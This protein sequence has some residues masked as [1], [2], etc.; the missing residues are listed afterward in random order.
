MDNTHFVKLV[1]HY[2]LISFQIRNGNDVV[3]F[4][5][6]YT[7]GFT[8]GVQYH[9][10]LTR[11]WNN[12][13]NTWAITVNGQI[14]GNTYSNSAAWPDFVASVLIGKTGD[15][16]KIADPST[17]P[18][19]T[20]NRPAFSPDGLLMAVGMATS[21]YIH[22]YNTSDWSKLPNPAVLPANAGRGVAFSPDGSLMAIAHSFSPYIT[23]YNTSDWS[24]LSN[25][26]TLPVGTG[27]DVDFNHDGSLMAVAH[28]TSPYVTI[29]NTSD[30]SKVTNPSTLPTGDA[31]G[32]N[33]NRDGSLLT[34]E[35]ANSPYVTIYNTSDWS[36]VT[37]PY[38]LPTGNGR[39]AAFNHDGSLM[40][41]AH[42][43][44]PFVTVYVPTQYSKG[45][46]DE[47]RISKGTGRWTANFTPSEQPYP[48]KDPGGGFSSNL[49]ADKFID[50]HRVD[51][52]QVW[53]KYTD[54]I[55]I[56]NKLTAGYFR[57]WSG[58]VDEIEADQALIVV[59]D[60]D[61]IAIFGIL[62][63]DPFS[64][65]YINGETQAQAVLNR[66][67]SD[68]KAPRLIIENAGGYYLSDIE[69]GDIIR[70][71]NMES[72]DDENYFLKQALLGLITMGT[73]L[74]RVIDINHRPDATI[75]IEAVIAT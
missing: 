51:L 46:K 50:D 53:L 56:K 1:V 20:G 3:N 25:P 6:V 24:K 5:R 69:R 32:V 36:K 67:L 52:G 21:P 18:T 9:F 47:Y 31:E 39:G 64:F 74:L 73:T 12:N 41:V 28:D 17:L 14:V 10:A 4:S 54:R 42:V 49:T 22:I 44:S 34:V 55:H 58:H 16:S 26:S 62:Q 60:V 57:Q 29:Y 8:A 63:G 70:F 40:A 35:H 23:I 30:W 45:H 38:T 19:G 15:W 72:L 59:T 75:Q 48:N 2:D 27:Y 43:T 65:P 61:S 11:G 33:F 68:L 13:D 71:D 66:K 37:N 7:G